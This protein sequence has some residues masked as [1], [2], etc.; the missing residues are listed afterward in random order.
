MTLSDLRNEAQEALDE[1]K[2]TLIDYDTLTFGPKIAQGAD[3]VVYKGTWGKSR[4]PI[5]IK[6]MGRFGRL[7]K[8]Q[9]VKLEKFQHEALILARLRHPNIVT[10]YGV[11]MRLRGGG[12]LG[13][14]Q[15]NWSDPSVPSA[16]SAAAMAASAAAAQ[17]VISCFL[18][19]EL[20]RNSLNN[21]EL[22]RALQHDRSGKLHSVVAQLVAGMAYLHENGVAHRD[23]KRQNVLL[24]DDWRVVKICDF[25]L[26]SIRNSDAQSMSVMVGTPAYMAPELIVSNL[27]T[28]LH[29]SL[30]IDVFS[31]GVLLWALWCNKN[32]YADE[33]KLYRLN[34]F[35][36]L[37]RIATGMRPI[38]PPTCPR[39]LHDV[40]CR[41]WQQAPGDR[42]SFQELAQQLKSDPTGFGLLDNAAQQRIQ[43]HHTARRASL[44]SIRRRSG[45]SG[46][47]SPIAIPAG[48]KTIQ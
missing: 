9:R 21:P 6:E 5:A 23:L 3:G 43:T 4:F 34:S 16:R 30:T 8:E 20:C 45:G 41:C 25:G 28:R 32:P 39:K 12:T 36:L 48:K 37:E 15:T 27:D 2:V 1:E 47:T 29:F 24:D 7:A 46:S 44:G 17:S 19:T 22:R 40:I 35:T 18:V 38:V 31:F 13:S 11:C 26:S 10:F 33:L 42:P 14:S